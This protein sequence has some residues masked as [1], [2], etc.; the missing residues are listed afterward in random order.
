[1]FLAGTVRRSLQRVTLY[2][3]LFPEVRDHKLRQHRP[4]GIGVLFSVLRIWIA[5]RM[6]RGY[7][8]EYSTTNK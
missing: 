4:P 3:E 8:T 5:S 1:M 6:I 7:S 2:A